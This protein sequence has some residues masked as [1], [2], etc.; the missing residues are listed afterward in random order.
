VAEAFF[1]QNRALTALANKIWGGWRR[2]PV[3]GADDTD[4]VDDTDGFFGV[5]TY[6]ILGTIFAARPDLLFSEGKREL[7]ECAV[8]GRV[9]DAA[10]W[11]FGIALSGGN[12][13]GHKMNTNEKEFYWQGR[14]LNFMAEC[15]V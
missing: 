4:F 5:G 10:G 9:A 15:D 13:A 1:W 11:G 7:F 3:F 8:R 14:V 12:G 6:G 2:G